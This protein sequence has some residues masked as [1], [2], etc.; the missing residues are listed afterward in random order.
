M[1][2]CASG[3]GRCPQSHRSIQQPAKL[4]MSLAIFPLVTE[5]IRNRSLKEKWLI[6]APADDKWATGLE[7]ELSMAAR[8]GLDSCNTPAP[9]AAS[10]TKE[11]P[12]LVPSVTNKPIASC[13]CEK[14]NT[15]VTCF[16]LHKGEPVM[17]RLLPLHWLL[18]P[19]KKERKEE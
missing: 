3:S 15:A 19:L 2:G 14:D 5:G 18:L 7:R 6:C 11:D 4:I 8:K 12:N 1:L 9:K 10:G 16:W 13:I 17:P